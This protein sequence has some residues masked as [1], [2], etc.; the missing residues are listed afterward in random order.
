MAYSTN[1][2]TNP[3]TGNFEKISLNPFENSDG[4]SDRIAGWKGFSSRHRNI[5]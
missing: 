5:C 3:L 1:H 4:R 2:G